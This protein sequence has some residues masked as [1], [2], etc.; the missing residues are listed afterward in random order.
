VCSEI[1]CLIGNTIPVGWCHSA[2]IRESRLD[3][4]IILNQQA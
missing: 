1:A 3:G 2:L 4:G